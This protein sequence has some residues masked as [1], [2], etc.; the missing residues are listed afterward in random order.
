MQGAHFTQQRF[1]LFEVEEILDDGEISIL[2]D[3][4]MLTLTLPVRVYLENTASEH[5]PKME[6]VEHELPSPAFALVG[7]QSIKGDAGNSHLGILQVSSFSG[8]T[9]TY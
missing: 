1:E 8:A 6:R 3:D 2:E 7:T 5:P 9:I 4:E